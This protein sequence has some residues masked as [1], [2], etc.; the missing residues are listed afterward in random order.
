MRN[1]K[2]EIFLIL[3]VI[4]VVIIS[5]GL[6]VLYVYLSIKYANIPI[7]DV[8]LWIIWFLNRGGR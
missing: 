7:K 4:I 5:F 2:S 6:V 3:F 8:P 1:K